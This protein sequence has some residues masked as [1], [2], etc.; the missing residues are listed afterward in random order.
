MEVSS[1]RTYASVLL[2]SLCYDWSIQMSDKE[3][4]WPGKGLFDSMLQVL[5]C[6]N[7]QF[8]VAIL[9]PQQIYKQPDVETDEG[10]HLEK[11][12]CLWER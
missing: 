3:L 10:G 8:S 12:I 5:T 2:E 1:T 9:S 7:N 4:P 6:D 11:C